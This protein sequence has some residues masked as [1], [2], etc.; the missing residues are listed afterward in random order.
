MNRPLFRLLRLP[1]LFTAAGNPIAGYFLTR[2][3]DEGVEPV[4]LLALVGSGV[5]LYAFGMVFNDVADRS[6]DG[7]HRPIPAG[8]VSVFSAIVT[9]L[10]CLA[11]AIGLAAFVSNESLLVA[12]GVALAVLGYNL[13]LKGHRVLGPVG[14]G[15]CRAGNLLL[16]ASAGTLTAGGWE[17]AAL[18]LFAY[19]VVLT[20]ASGWE[21]RPIDRASVLWVRGAHVASLI[22]LALIAI[23]SPIG[24]F[25][26][27]LLALGLMVAYDG[28]T[29]GSVSPGSM[30]VGRLIRTGVLGILAIDAAL[31]LGRGVWMFSWVPVVLLIGAIFTGRRAT[32]S[33][34]RRE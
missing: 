11:G 17:G 8:E 24:W 32:I 10:L 14:M 21:D 19:V 9:G 12:T 25:P 29:S 2:S 34:L 5:G 33:G 31:L 22:A 26:L 30:A 7:P 3:P 13:L 16:G 27:A 15:L 20:V 4:P 1:A 28:V 18:G 23:E 6:T